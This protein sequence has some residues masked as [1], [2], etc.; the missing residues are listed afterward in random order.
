MGVESDLSTCFVVFST[1]QDLF[2][3]VT[4]IGYNNDRTMNNDNKGRTKQQVV[5]SYSK[6]YG[7]RGFIF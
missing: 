7:K 2:L 5:V 3:K 1:P 4:Q 6:T